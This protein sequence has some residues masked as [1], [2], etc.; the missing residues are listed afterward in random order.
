MELNFGGVSFP[1]YTASS[2]SSSRVGK[3]YFYCSECEEK[4]EVKETAHRNL[5]DVCGKELIVEHAEAAAISVN[6]EEEQQWSAAIDFLGEDVRGMLEMANGMREPHRFLTENSLK[7]LSRCVVDDNLSILFD[8]KL[9]MGP[10][11]AM[12]I[13]ASFS[14]PVNGIFGNLELVVGQP[15]YGETSLVNAE[16]CKGRVLLL[17][18]GRV[19]FAA[20]YMNA[21]AAGAAAL[22]IVQTLD[23]WPFVM[24]DSISELAIITSRAIPC[25]MI[26]KADGLLLESLYP[27]APL[28]RSSSSGITLSVLNA[29]NECSICQETMCKDDVVLKLLCRHVY[30]DSCVSEWL[31]TKNTC[32]LCR[33]ELPTQ[34]AKSKSTGLSGI[35][36]ASQALYL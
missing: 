16:F 22:L 33:D 5:C 24:T 15:E 20:K 14:M 11:Q 7:A 13:P 9:N 27:Q 32:P 30:H 4:R 17:K 18:R 21:I 35:S 10:L 29:V 36:E 34:G 12:L 6:L 23:V 1:F 2:S 19:S 31:R 28:G 8:C 26:S 25:F 3:P